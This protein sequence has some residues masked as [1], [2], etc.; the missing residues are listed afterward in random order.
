MNKKIHGQKPKIIPPPNLGVRA[1][2]AA[3]LTAPTLLG[4]W[5]APRIYVWL[6]GG[7]R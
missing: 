2:C 7:P 4:V 6:N 5:K 3:F 1:L